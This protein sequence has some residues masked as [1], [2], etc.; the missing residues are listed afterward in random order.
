MEH[1]APQTEPA[2]TGVCLLYMGGPETLDD[3]RPFLLN[4]FSDR[5][6]I[7]LPGGR[8]LQ[9]PMA[10]LIASRR[11]P[12]VEGYYREIG[13]GSPLLRITR[14]QA[15]LLQQALDRR[16]AFRVELA[17]RYCAPR[18]DEALD[19]LDAAGARRVLALPLYPQYSAATTG[20]SL[21]EL[22]RALA[23]RG[24]GWDLI[25]VRDFHDHPGYLDA[26]AGTVRAGLQLLDGD[27]CVVFSAHSL[28]Q[29]M[30]DRG[31]PYQRQVQATVAGVVQRL[32]LEQRWHLGYQSRSG[33]VRWLEP[34]LTGLTDRL[35]DRGERRLL[36]VPVSFVSDHIETLH[37]I[38]IRLRQRC[39][40]RGAQ[41]FVRAPSL[42]DDPGFITA[43]EEMVTS[44]C[45]S[46]AQTARPA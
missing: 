21:G 11:A 24:P 3:V 16:G 15:R 4:L 30:I 2:P 36:V 44:R 13:G 17:M 39:K 33:P 38:D 42:N 46:Q 28:P 22:R 40:D 19:R 26:L 27:A 8:L 23:G 5:E 29:R 41:V 14:K 32:G 9:R 34:E 7:R 1:P 18:V 37:E 20:S 35:L 25:E 45:Q 12:R 10:R 31:D 43:L 6:L